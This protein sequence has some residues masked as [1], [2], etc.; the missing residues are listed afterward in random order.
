VSAHELIPVKTIQRP[1]PV[2]DPWT[3]PAPAWHSG[4][5]TTEVLPAKLQVQIKAE[6]DLM[7]S[8]VPPLAVDQGFPATGLCERQINKAYDWGEIP[9]ICTRDLGHDGDC[10]PLGPDGHNYLHPKPADPDE[11]DGEP[12]TAPDRPRDPDTGR[13]LPADEAKAPDPTPEETP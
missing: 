4:G 7:V 13:F 6:I 8:K 9:F 10:A 1:R 2:P 11:A 12:E 5:I 3:E